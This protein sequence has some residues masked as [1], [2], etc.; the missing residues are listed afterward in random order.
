[1]IVRWFHMLGAMALV[2]CAATTIALAD[3]TPKIESTPI[4][5][6]PKPDFS[7]MN[8]NLGSWTCSSQS[9]RRPAPYITHSVTTID[10]TGYWMVTKSTT[11]KTSW[12]PETRSTDW[13]TWDSDANRWADMNLG[14]YGAYDTT[15][16]PGWTG[17]AMVWTDVLFKPGK[18]VVAVTP[19]TSTKVSNTKITQHST[20][21]ERGS[22][23]WIS[24]D[25]VCNKGM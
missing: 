21:K 10:P 5:N 1:M 17:N 3:S 7:S 16:S 19:M 4:P 14:D 8:F 15:T 23:R 18:D 6:P 9:S 13:V 22:G 25:A 24:V 11:A 12:A 20:F 2:V